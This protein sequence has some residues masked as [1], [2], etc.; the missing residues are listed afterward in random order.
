MKINKKEVG[1]VVALAKKVK[2]LESDNEVSLKKEIQETEHIAKLLEY[3]AEHLNPSA[4]IAVHQTNYFP[5]KGTILP[6]GHSITTLFQ[7]H[8]ARKIIEDLQLKYPRM[9]VH[10]TLNY[11][12]E[13]VAAGG[14][15]KTWNARYAVLVPVKDILS[16][17]VCLNPVDTWVIG[18]ITMA[19][20]AEIIMPEDEYNLNPKNWKTLA[21]NAKIVTYP[22][23]KS[24]SDFIKFRIVQKGYTLTDAADHGWYESSD[25]SFISTFIK[26]SQFL[27]DEEKDRLISV[28]ASK[29]YH[30]WNQIFWAMAAKFQKETL[31]H[32]HSNWREIEVLIENVYGVMFDPGYAEQRKTL[33]LITFQLQ[34]LIAQLK[35]HKKEIETF[36]NDGKELSP[37][38][39]ET[40]SLAMLIFE[41]NKIQSW[42]ENTIQKISR[43]S[44]SKPMTW[45][46]YLMQEKIM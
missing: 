17:V 44:T 43:S 29:G 3:T 40:E 46:E 21:G 32:F 5:K 14:E 26:R 19:S 20:S 34:D 8:S 38:R 13:G 7:G 27:S 25:L 12:V 24:L 37:S 1:G 9:T 22:K 6:N 33:P 10:F 4:L 39:E 15:W 41:L 2:R 23:N 30:N 31:P 18:K 36:I 35:R 42:L 45:K 28:A 11:P 16:R